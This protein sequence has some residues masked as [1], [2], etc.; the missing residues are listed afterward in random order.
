MMLKKKLIPMYPKK[1][2]QVN[3]LHTYKV[4]TTV[5]TFTWKYE[6]QLPLLLELTVDDKSGVMEKQCSIAEDRI[7]S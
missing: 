3:N 7:V 6:N 1:R 4:Q 2:K 5:V